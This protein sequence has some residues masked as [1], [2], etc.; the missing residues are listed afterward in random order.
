[1][2]RFTAPLRV[3]SQ[4][5]RTSDGCPALASTEIDNEQRRYTQHRGSAR[6]IA[7]SDRGRTLACIGRERT[8]ERSFGGNEELRGRVADSGPRLSGSRKR[9]APVAEPGPS[10]QSQQSSRHQASA[11]RPASVIFIR[12]GL[13][14]ARTRPAAAAGCLASRRASDFF[15]TAA[16]ASSTAPSP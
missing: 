9:Q 2:N 15:S 7:R 1:V 8:F 6:A 14:R 3:E 11:F 5:G 12:R 4:C 10:C 16:L 13:R